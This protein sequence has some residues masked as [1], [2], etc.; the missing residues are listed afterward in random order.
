MKVPLEMGPGRAELRDRRKTIEINTVFGP[1]LKAST[2]SA[3]HPTFQTY[4]L[5][6]YFVY[7]NT[8]HAVHFYYNSWVHCLCPLFKYCHSSV[9]LLSIV[10]IKNP[11]SFQSL[12]LLLY[13]SL[14]HSLPNKGWIWIIERQIVFSSKWQWYSWQSCLLTSLGWKSVV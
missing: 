14:V 3:F 1:T 11:L 5:L 13:F 12:H 4:L 6:I 2:H 9:M 7:M 10:T 8:E